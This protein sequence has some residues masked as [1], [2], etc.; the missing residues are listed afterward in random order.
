MN[1]S[2]S[3]LASIADDR[4]NKRIEQMLV[5]VVLKRPRKRVY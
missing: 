4:L 1:L 2:L 3:C 5:K